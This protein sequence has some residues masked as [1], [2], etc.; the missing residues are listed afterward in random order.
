MKSLFRSRAQAF[1]LSASIDWL[2]SGRLI[3]ERIRALEEYGSAETLCGFL[4]FRQEPDL[5]PLYGEW[6]SRG[7]GVYFPRFS[8]SEG[9]Y[10]MAL[11]TDISSQLSRGHYGIMEPVSACPL[12]SSCGRSM[13]WL[14]PGLSF[15]PETGVRLGRGRGYYD[16]LLAGRPGLKIGVATEGQLMEGLP[17]EGHDIRMDVI[18]TENRTVRLP[19]EVIR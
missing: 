18:V 15:C 9:H 8:A 3:A 11:V 6:L 2:Q 1:L 10:E 7:R 4:S 14:V 16:R 12:L 5:S 13:V 17:S 19:R